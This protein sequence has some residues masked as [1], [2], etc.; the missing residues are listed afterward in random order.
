M[1]HEAYCFRNFFKCS[2]CEEMVDKNQKIEH[3]DEIHNKVTIFPEPPSF[4]L[5]PVEL[6]ALQSADW[7]PE[8]KKP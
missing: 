7:S 2:Q 4:L 8:F 6:Q 1:V 3:Q 5:A